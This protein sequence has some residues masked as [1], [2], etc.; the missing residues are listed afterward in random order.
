MGGAGM[1]AYLDGIIPKVSVPEG[2]SGRWSV[3]H[4]DVEDSII[5]WLR[6]RHFEPGRYTQLFHGGRLVMSDTPA[7]RYDHLPFVRAAT[8]DVL[9]SGLGLGMCLGAVL[10]KPEVTS[11]TIIEIDPDVIALVAPS[12]QDNRIS[13]V[14]ADAR[15]WSPPKG[16][17]YG[18]VWHDI[19][20]DICRDNLSEMHTLNRRYARRA[21]WK[22]CWSQNLMRAG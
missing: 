12:Y 9:I 14:Q 19:W 15:S 21:S 3:R 18:A 2:S 20:P 22:G 17:K 4:V 10:K 6:E 5:A 13:I 7:E 1:S 11:V 16:R 8:G